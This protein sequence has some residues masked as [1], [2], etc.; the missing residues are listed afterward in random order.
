MS[1]QGT[2]QKYTGNGNFYNTHSVK[3]V[4][5]LNEIKDFYGEIYK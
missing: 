4:K 2:S 5:G 3:D 1:I